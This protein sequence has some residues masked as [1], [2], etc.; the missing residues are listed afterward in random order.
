MCFQFYIFGSVFP[1]DFLKNP[2]NHCRKNPYLQ[3]KFGTF[4]QH[5]YKGARHQ[6]TQNGFCERKVYHNFVLILYNF[7]HRVQN[8]VHH[9]FLRHRQ[10]KFGGLVTCNP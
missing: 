6:P 2:Y 1:D 10:F 8:F 7:V 3:K 9:S 5:G 4:F